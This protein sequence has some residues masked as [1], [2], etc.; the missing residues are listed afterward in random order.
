[1]A[2]KLT[3][4][5]VAQAYAALASGDRSRIEQYWDKDMVWLVP[6]RNQLS[7][8][9]RGLDGF[10][11]FMGAVGKMSNNSFNM[12]NVTT[13]VND[14]YSADVTR[15]VGFRAGRQ[16][17]PPTPYTRLEIDVVHVLR[18][19]NGKVIEGRGAIFGDGTAQYDSFWSRIGAE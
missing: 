18:W 15:N 8:T 17:S 1:V 6:G 4:E 3:P 13:M 2:I 16:D 11:E 19:R 12:S 5:L 10:L 14:E 9:W 7:G